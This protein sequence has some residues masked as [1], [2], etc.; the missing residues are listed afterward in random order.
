[1]FGSLQERLG[2][3]G[4]C[5][6]PLGV[7]AADLVSVVGGFEALAGQLADC[8]QHPEAPAG[9]PNEAFVD[10]RLQRVDVGAGDLL[11]GLEGAAAGEDGQAREQLPLRF[12]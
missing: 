8:L 10:Q 11:G 5:E 7:P 6:E 3:L 9:P 4:K 1:M 2:A 12:A